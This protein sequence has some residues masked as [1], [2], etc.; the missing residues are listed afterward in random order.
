MNEKETKNKRMSELIE[1][2]K[3]AVEEAYGSKYEREWLECSLPHSYGRSDYK[4]TLHVYS[5]SPPKGYVL[6]DWCYGIVKAYT[7]QM[8]LIRT[9]KLKE[10]VCI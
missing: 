9:Y 5:G 4:V 3:R 10:V 8:R 7:L 2:G 6:A 1:K